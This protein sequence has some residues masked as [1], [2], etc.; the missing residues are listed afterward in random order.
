MLNI[1]SL[2]PYNEIKENETIKT[3][4]PFEAIRESVRTMQDFFFAHPKVVEGLKLRE[5]T[6]LTEEYRKELKAYSP[7]PE[8]IQVT[9]IQEWKKASPEE[10]AAARQEFRNHKDQ[11]IQEWEQIHGKPWLRYTEDVYSDQGVL[12]RRKGDLYDA[13]HVQPLEFGGKNTAENLTPLHA[14]D[15]YDHQGIHSSDGVYQKIK[16]AFE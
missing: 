5:A 6:D 15:H 1:E 3:E 10:V 8:T 2:N 7:Y 16:D 14:H 13:H 4:S 9:D 11:L 12:I